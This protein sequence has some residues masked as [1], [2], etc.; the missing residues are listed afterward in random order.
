MKFILLQ[1]LLLFSF[2]HFIRLHFELLWK[3]SNAP[4][5]SI[6][7]NLN[8]NECDVIIL[9]IIRKMAPKTFIV[10]HKIS[11]QK[12]PQNR[13]RLCATKKQKKK[14]PS[15][16]RNQTACT[17]QCNRIWFYFWTHKTCIENASKIKMKRRRK[18]KKTRTEMRRPSG[19]YVGRCP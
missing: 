19:D 15:G 8:A 12:K 7:I 11:M 10:D 16:K 2:V 9:K 17:L 13:A 3:N 1:C 18:K 14:K 4:N 5:R 6:F